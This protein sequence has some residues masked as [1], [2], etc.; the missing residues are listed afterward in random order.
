MMVILASLPS[1]ESLAQP[2]ATF[3]GQ[4]LVC[5][6]GV[7]GGNGKCETGTYLSTRGNPK[8]ATSRTACEKGATAI[9]F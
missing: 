5:V 1:S 8:T 3:L 4:A 6:L 2:A 7:E 9:F